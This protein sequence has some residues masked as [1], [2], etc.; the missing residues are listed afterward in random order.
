MRSEGYACE[1]ED[2][3]EAMIDNLSS[4]LVLSFAPAAGILSRPIHNLV[5]TEDFKY[6]QDC[7]PENCL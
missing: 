7:S 2:E 6:K 3:V 4:V 1:E 5:L